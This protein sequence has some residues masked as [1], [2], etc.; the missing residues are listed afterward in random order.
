MN[1]ITKKFFQRKDA[2]KAFGNTDYYGNGGK[3][4]PKMV[5]SQ[6]E[7]EEY[8]YGDGGEIDELYVGQSVMLK[9]ASSAIKHRFAGR[10]IVIEKKNMN[11]SFSG[12]DRK[13]GEKTPF[14]IYAEDVEKYGNGGDVTAD[15]KYSA[16][17]AG[18]RIGKK[19][20]KIAMSDGSKF[21]RRN[22]NQYGQA[23]GGEYYE[24]RRNR[25]DKRKTL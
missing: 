19:V 9:N 23:G 20:S 2:S 4:K 16:M 24:S 11:G 13:T 22:M 1:A 10:E 6:F 8:E 25:T 18:R 3:V 14:N 15:R 7:E 17:K 12:F 21:K 5:R